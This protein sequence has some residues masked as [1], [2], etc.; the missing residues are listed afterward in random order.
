MTAPQ[1]PLVLDAVLARNE[2]ANRKV[3]ALCDGRESER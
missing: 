3:D 2:R 1:E